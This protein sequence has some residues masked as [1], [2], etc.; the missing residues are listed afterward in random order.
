MRKATSGTAPV[1]MRRIAEA[2]GVSRPAVSMI[3]GGKGQAFSA[4]LRERVQRTA[5]ELGY[6]PNQGAY[7]VKTGRFGALALLLD[8][9]CYLPPALLRALTAA[10]S[11]RGLHLVVADCSD[12]QLLAE[13]SKLLSH[14]LADGLLLNRIS[15]PTPAVLRRLD[16]H[17]L[18]VCWLNQRLGRGCVLPDDPEALRRLVAELVARGHR[19]IAYSELTRSAHGHASEDDRREGYLAGM[20]AHGLDPILWS[21]RADS[22]EQRVAVALRQLREPERPDALLCYGG[23]GMYP[24]LAAALRL[25]LEIPRDL[26]LAAC[27]ET[28]HHDDTGLVLGGLL[29]PWEA[30]AEAAVARLAAGERDTADLAVPYGAFMP[31][32][33]VGVRG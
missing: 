9:D 7:A 8:Q 22:G 14:L 2:C 16:A 19:R 31:G 24:Y 21:E 20:R 3:L 4:E 23:R 1:T 11:R 25:G 12:G 13:E 30:I 26:S 33:T 29:T 18:P 28:F 10:C 5:R 17:P 6:R 27:L 32:Q 15:V